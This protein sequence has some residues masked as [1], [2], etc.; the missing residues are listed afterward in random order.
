MRDRVSPSEAEHEPRE[1]P[2]GRS[3]S[4]RLLWTLLGSL[5]A[6]ATA[7][8]IVDPGRIDWLRAA[9]IVFGALV[10]QASPLV[11]VGA[12]ASAAI[13]VFVPPS[14]LEKLAHL[15]RPLQ[16]PAAALAGFAF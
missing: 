15:P 10:I 13:E 2:S 7:V 6:L 3:A 1:L 4:A 12:F 11:L 14:K 9:L 16:P 8:R 5:V